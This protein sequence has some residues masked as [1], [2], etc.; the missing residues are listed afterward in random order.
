MRC[1]PTRT[2]SFAGGAIF[3]L[4]E[5]RFT[6]SVVAMTQHRCSVP[7]RIRAGRLAVGLSMALAV[8]LSGWSYS[9]LAYAEDPA[10]PAAEQAAADRY[11]VTV[12]GMT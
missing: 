2:S 9:P 3:A 10:A 1:P 12:S 4:T 8:T 6:L 7:P 11:V 5:A